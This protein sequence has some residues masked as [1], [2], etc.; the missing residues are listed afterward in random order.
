MEDVVKGSECPTRVIS[1]FNAEHM[2]TQNHHDHRLQFHTH[3][4]GSGANNSVKHK[5]T[6]FYHHRFSQK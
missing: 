6:N 1:P 5:T 2:P 4:K 3:L